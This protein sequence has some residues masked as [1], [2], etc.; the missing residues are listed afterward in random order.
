M[1]LKFRN[2]LFVSMFLLVIGVFFTGVVFAADCYLYADSTNCTAQTDC[3][4][5]NNS[6]GGGWCEM[7]G[8]WSF[9]GNQSACTIT[10][11]GLGLSCDWKPNDLNQNTWCPIKQIGDMSP[12]GSITNSSDIGCCEMEGCWSRAGTNESYCENPGFFSGICEWHHKNASDPLNYDPY[13][14][15]P[16]GCCVVPPCQMF[17]GNQTKCDAAK[18][19]GFNCNWDDPNCGSGG[20]EQYANNSADCLNHGCSYKSLGGECNPPEF[21]GGGDFGGGMGAEHCWFA[22]QNPNV[23][24]NITGCIYCTN[25]ANLIGNQSGGGNITN[26]SSYCYGKQVGYCE[27]HDLMV[28]ASFIENSLNLTASSLPLASDNIECADILIKQACDCGP[29]QMCKW[30]NS[31]AIFGNTTNNYCQNI[32]R[33]KT[34]DE[35]TSCRPTI[36]GQ[37]IK[38]CEDPKITNEG[39]CSFLNTNFNMP[40]KWSNTTNKCVFM[41]ESVF[42]TGGIGDLWE[43]DNTN[44]GETACMAAKGSWNCENYEAD[45]GSIQEDCFCETGTTS[46]GAMV[47]S[48]D[49]FCPACEFYYSNG[50]A[51]TSSA[52]AEAACANSLLG[53]CQFETNT[54]APNTYGF[55]KTPMQFKFGAGDCKS[56]CKSCGMVSDNVT[57][58]QQSCEA[59]PAGCVWINSSMGQFCQSN[60]QSSCDK[61]CAACLNQMDCEDTNTPIICEWSTTYCKSPGFQGEICF[62]GTDNDGDMQVDCSDSDCM[63]NEACGGGAFG[64][65]GKYNASTCAINVVDLVGTSY[66]CTWFT[67]A[68]SNSSRCS[69]PGENCWMY[70]ENVTGC[71]NMSGCTWFANISEQGM[72]GWCNINQT[73]MNACNQIL[74]SSNCNSSIGCNWTDF[75]GPGP[76]PGMCMLGVFPQCGPL[77]SSQCEANTNCTWK[78]DMMMGPAPPGS[79]GGMCE[80]ACFNDSLN[81]ETCEAKSFCSWKGTACMPAFTTSC[82]VYDG[83]QTGCEQQPLCQYY[84]ST[85]EDLCDPKSGGQAFSGMMG[86]GNMGEMNDEQMGAF[87]F[88]SL[89]D[90]TWHDFNYPSGWVDETY[91]NDI[92]EALDIRYFGTKDLGDQIGIGIG[93]TQTREAALCAGKPDHWPDDGTMNN[94]GQNATKYYWYLDTN[95]NETDNCEATDQNGEIVSG[96]DFL[97]TAYTT[98][99]T[100]DT[101][102]FFM[103]QNAQWMPVSVPLYLD[104]TVSCQFLGGAGIGVDKSSLE[105]FPNLYNSSAPMR[106]FVEAGHNSTFIVDSAGPG[107]YTSGTVDFKPECCGSADS[108]LDCDGDGIPA[109]SSSKCA[110]IKEKGFMSFEDCFNGQDDNSDGLTDCND[111]HCMPMPKCGGTFNFI[112][113]ANDKKAPTVMF[114]KADAWPDG[115]FVK[116]DTD[117]PAKGWVKFYKNDSSCSSLNKT[118][119]DEGDPSVTFDDYKPFHGTNLD[120][121]SL[122]YALDLSTAYYYK[123]RV[124][125]PSSNAGESACLNFTTKSEFKK[126]LFDVD[127]DSGYTVDFNCIGFNKTNW[128]GEYAIK[129]NLSYAKNC[130]LTIKCNNGNY[131]MTMVGVDLTGPADI[132]LQGK[133]VCNPSQKMIGMDSGEETW[134]ETLYALGMGGAGD[135][136]K[137]IYPIAYASGNKIYH[138][139]EDNINDCDEITDYADCSG[140]T[141]QTACYIPTSV[142]YSAH[143]IQLA[144]APAGDTPPSGG[145]G[146]GGGTLVLT[147]TTNRTTT[148]T[149]ETAAETGEEDTTGPES[150]HSSDESAPMLSPETEGSSKIIFFAIIGGLVVLGIIGLLIGVKTLKKAA[151]KNARLETHHHEH[152]ASDNTH[153]LNSHSL[154]SF[155]SFFF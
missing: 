68:W 17:N 133:L 93:V 46:S 79:E 137:E 10:A 72:E 33:T 138:C 78:T 22:D 116:F 110:S 86:G 117:E 150:I 90:D 124:E 76:A 20:C 38:F 61:D 99:N 60:S 119:V 147:N 91:Y 64:D 56:D 107:Y 115:A 118:I 6:M 141:T 122:G 82:M 104:K 5:K 18:S 89:G 13:C 144:A 59:S 85:G 111:P 84:N 94:T 25:D 23:C 143:L 29:F 153:H 95:G 127:L 40:C 36:E 41:F 108:T 69:N 114:Q 34:T 129:V 8:C 155:Y 106:I 98:S 74:N 58:Q 130:N 148:T 145:G 27:G 35:M 101:K 62:D 151:K 65:C 109:S 45:D 48:C 102:S 43:I 32:N 120:V 39:N 15:D 16:I 77:N 66:N 88:F 96:F 44:G 71:G 21:S 26:T 140:N 30:S 92:L 14:P 50:T 142:G 97:I 28:T 103:C 31:S 123:V 55:C 134:S 63:F 47:E 81:T 100:T 83:N 154:R 1:V 53:Y 80:P 105:K 54:N 67:D 112:A 9:N 37:D 125:D 24:M 4:W 57:K 3:Q 7:L 70:E 135:K 131:Q 152:H 139:D 121:N 128:T 51:I 132:D 12:Y 42:K 19:L 75:D 87:E 149:P 126:V 49:S 73:N 11:G 2:L 136:I 146:G 113:N 52:E